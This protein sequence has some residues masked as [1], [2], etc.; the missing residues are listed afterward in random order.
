MNL[1]NEVIFITDADSSSGQVLTNCL[2]KQGA[3]F[4]LNSVSNGTA[5]REVLEK[6]K[7]A[8]SNV[9]LV[10]VDLCNHSAVLAMLERAAEQLGT[11]DVLIHN[12][13]VVQSTRVETCDEALFLELLN[14]NA[15]SAFIC[16]QV[17]GR[18][19]MAK[20]KGRIVYVSSIHAEK[21]TGSSFVYSVSKGAV[22]MLNREAALKFGRY[23]VNVNAIEL[24][25]I[26]GDDALFRSEISTLYDA[27][28][29]KVPNAIVGNYDDLAQLV[30]YLCS[31]EARFVNGADIRLDGGFLLHYMDAKMRRPPSFQGEVL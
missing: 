3:R 27:Y 31:D 9:V 26:E 29:Y 16:T 21:P 17:V 7:S 24:G 1:Q 6:C 30:I 4:I 2:A 11:V 19:M 23:G 18:Q 28:Q 13:N 22:K 8:G 25:A 20:Q 12:N 5:N 15:K 14:V 10:N